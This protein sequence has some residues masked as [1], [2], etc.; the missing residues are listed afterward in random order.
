MT[1]SSPK[2]ATNSLNICAGPQRTCREAKNSG[3]SNIT[4]AT[5]TPAN[6]PTIWATM[7]GRHV[8]PG[9]PALRRVGERDGRIEVRARDRAERQDQRDERRAGREGVREQRHRDVAA[10]EALAHDAGADDG[11]QQQRRTDGFGD[12]APA[13]IGLRARSLTPRAACAP[14]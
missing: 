11:R 4:C 7:Y 3:S 13:E 10:G 5:A 6:A 12:E 1:A 9:Q 14:G 8:A 2:V